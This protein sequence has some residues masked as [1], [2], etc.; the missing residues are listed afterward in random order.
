MKKFILILMIFLLF[1][2]VLSAHQPRL[3]YNLENSEDNPI[4][5]KSPEISKAYY[6]ELKAQPDYYMIESQESFNLYLNILSPDLEDSKTDF[7]VEVILD[8]DLLFVLNGSQE[9]WKIFHE[10]F[11]G[12]SYLKGPEIEKTV[13]PGIY[14]IKVSNPLNTGKY[15][16]AVGKI[17]SF[18]FKEIVKTFIVLPKLKKDFFEKSPL[19]AYFNLM[20]LFL[21]IFLVITAGIVIGII[22]VVKKLNKKLKVKTK[23][24]R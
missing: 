22:F 8:D 18:P 9:E 4:I 5:I 12:D 10:E 1:I 11:A 19:T 24:I 6:G 2:N 16:L 23:T 13:E 14:Y 17:E 21:L 3:V 7:N 15:S 20:G